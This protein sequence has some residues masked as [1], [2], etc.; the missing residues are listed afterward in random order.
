M[1][2]I[3]LRY[4]TLVCKL[5]YLIA[6]MHEKPSAREAFFVSDVWISFFAL[7]IIIVNE[8]MANIS[9]ID[10]KRKYTRIPIHTRVNLRFSDG[11]YEQCETRDLC[12][13]GALVM[14]VNDRDEGELCEV[15]FSQAGIVNNR[16][17]TLRGEVVRVE[18]QGIALVFYDM[19]FSSYTYL[20]TI[21]N[22]SSDD[23]FKHAE[24]FLDRIATIEHA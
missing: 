15:E 5:P 9:N 19:N 23:V 24:E 7:N 16:I 4:R 22:E 12:L 17:L 13:C 1:L 18:E 8:K 21:I 10:E 20:Q 6:S 14:G 2:R 11:E 3:S